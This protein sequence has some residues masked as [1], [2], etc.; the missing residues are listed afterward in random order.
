MLKTL[1]AVIACGL[2]ASCTVGIG[3]G[4]HSKPPFTEGLTEPTDTETQL[5]ENEELTP[6]PEVV[7]TEEVVKTKAQPVNLEVAAY[8]TYEK[9]VT[10]P[11]TS[12]SYSYENGY[13]R[14]IHSSSTVTDAHI[15]EKSIDPASTSAEK[16]LVKEVVKEEKPIAPEAIDHTQN[17]IR[18]TSEYI[19]HI[20]Q[21]K[22]YSN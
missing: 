10:P 9:P 3:L 18:N 13:D 21:G 14:Y 8:H 20:K 5:A 19:D 22:I 16:F 6:M 11:L 2:F 4:S 1:F 15:F 12:S 7:E 17:E